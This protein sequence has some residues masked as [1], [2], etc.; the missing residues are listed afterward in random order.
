MKKTYLLGLLF[1]IAGLTAYAQ[2]SETTIDAKFEEL[3]TS[4][5]NF[6]GYKVVDSGE[7]TNL[8]QLTSQRIAELKQ[9][10]AAS[11][12]SAQAQ[13]EKISSLE[14]SMADLEAR[15]ANVTAEKDAIAFLGIPF[16]KASY[17]NMMWG[18][19]G[20]LILALLFFVYRFKRSHEHTR[21]AR[22]RHAET[23]KEFEAYR[24]KALEKEQRLGRLL[25]DE[26]NK[27]VQ[28][29]K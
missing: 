13:K 21:E 23:E 10:I 6:K 3:I 16:S 26:K 22:L 29:S 12:E 1:L 15:L 17:K 27:Q 7:L 18:I 19:V 25:Q 8:Q 11:N 5:N 9:E 28:M 20:A 4:S 2:T 24:A 14:E